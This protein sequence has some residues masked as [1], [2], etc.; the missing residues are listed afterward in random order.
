M[1]IHSIGQTVFSLS[2][3]EGITLGEGEDIDNFPGGAGGWDVGRICEAGDRASEGQAVGVYGV[4]FTVGSLARKGVSVGMRG[5]G[6]KVSSDKE[7]MKV[8]MMAEGD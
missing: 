8:G 2:H 4:G 5:M 7:L 3:I 1:A 6:N